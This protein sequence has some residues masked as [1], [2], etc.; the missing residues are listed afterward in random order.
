MKT[1]PMHYYKRLLIVPAL[2]S[3]L[4]IGALGLWRLQ[5]GIDLVGGSLLQISFDGTLPSTAAIT[6]AADQAGI[7]DV[8]VQ[9]AGTNG[10]IIRA[11]DLS[12]QEKDAFESKLSAL[13]TM[14]EDE[15]DSVGP[16]IGQEL[17]QKGLVALGLVALSVV[18]FIAWALR[19]VSKPVQSWK[20]GLV[21]IAT[22]VHDI[23]IPVG[24]FAFLGHLQGAEVDSLF[25][26]ALLTLLGVSINNTIVVFDRIREN[27]RVNQEH[28]KREEFD[29]VVGHSIMQTL[30]R[31]INTSLTV[32]IVLAALYVL[33]PITTQDFA[34]TLIV[35]VVAGTYS[36]IFLAAPLLVWIEKAQQ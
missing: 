9:P 7:G 8:R 11:R 2:I 4:A 33:G 32:V 35:G 24:L 19:K 22:L 16:T 23:L 18:L 10:Y 3:L 14:H 20:Y 13:G 36:S 28:N 21:A 29:Q 26:V 12:T 5:P 17:L 15:F 34:L 27:L 1:N 31:S 25:I 30:S 6:S